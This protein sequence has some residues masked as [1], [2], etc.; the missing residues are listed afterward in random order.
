[1]MKRVLIAANW[2]MNKTVGEA[3]RYI[4]EFLPRMA[5]WEQT[6]V[7]I[8]P[9]FTCLAYLNGALANTG[10]RLGA[11]NVFW[12][13]QGAFTGEVSATMLVDMGCRYVIIGHSERRHLL[14]ENNHDIN[15]KLKAASGCGLIPIF[16]VGETLPEREKGLAHSVVRQQLEQ[17]LAGIEIGKAVIAYEPVWAI[18]TGLNASPADAQEVCGSIRNWMAGSRGKDW[19]ENIP[20]LYGGSVTIQNIANL[21]DQPDIDGALVGG[22]SLDP[23]KFAG[24]ARLRADG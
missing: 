5:G 24:I 12:E 18:G 14:G 21:I 3:A 15:R 2:K 11:Q 19:A 17:G 9:P 8:C 13:S 1:M 16:C 6:E 7:V 20:I 4:D 10:I 23:E 22:A